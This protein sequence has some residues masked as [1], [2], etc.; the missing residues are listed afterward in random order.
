MTIFIRPSSLPTFGDCMRRGAVGQFRKQAEDAGFKFPD[1]SRGIAAII[2]S[3]VHAGAAEVLRRED[4]DAQEDA[5]LSYLEKEIED[6]STP[7]EWDKITAPDM[8]A[9]ETQTLRMLQAYR[10]FVPENVAPY[11]IEERNVCDVGDGFAVSGQTDSVIGYA[12]LGGAY[13]LRDIKTSS[14]APNAAAQVGTYELIQ[15]AHGIPIKAVYIDLIRRGTLKKPQEP[16]V[17]YRIDV[18][19]A[20]ALAK[21]TIA[22]VKG[23][24]RRWI[25]AGGNP[26]VWPANP[27]SMLCTAKYCPAHP[28]NGSGFCTLP[29]QRT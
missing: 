18:E 17:S 14:R 12:D 23:Y 26:L 29:L 28:D 22:S 24:Y 4:E 8:D 2:G 3:A 1:K 16:V 27:G 15:D 20:N 25:N 5:A 6:S 19:A 10:E 9:A 11:S 21:Q 13:E 7:I